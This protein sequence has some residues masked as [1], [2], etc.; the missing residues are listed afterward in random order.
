MNGRIEGFIWPGW[1][2]N[3]ITVQHGV[4]L[5]EVEAVFFNAPAIV[6]KASTG[7]YLLYGQ[8]DN[9]RYLLLVFV[10]VGRQVKIFAARD[11]TQRERR[12]L[13]GK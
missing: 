3:K 5:D 8:S 11:M 13:R 1:L 2:L 7:K 4:E 6:R 9:G 10:W 12:Y